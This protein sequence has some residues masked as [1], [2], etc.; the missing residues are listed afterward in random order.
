MV[1]GLKI[2]VMFSFGICMVIIVFYSVGFFVL[3]IKLD[4][5]KKFREF[6]DDIKMI[7]MYE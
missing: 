5:I 1:I 6:G 2:G 3:K 7:I 4:R